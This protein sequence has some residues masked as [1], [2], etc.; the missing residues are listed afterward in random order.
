MMRHMALEAMRGALCVIMPLT[1]QQR[2]PAD[3]RYLT[4][5]DD[6][7][8]IPALRNMVAIQPIISAIKTIFPFSIT[9][10]TAAWNPH[11]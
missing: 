4:Q 6:L 11:L 3:M 2:L 7:H 1:I 10:E 9:N 8:N 5:L